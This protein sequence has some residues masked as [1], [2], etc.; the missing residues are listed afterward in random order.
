MVLVVKN[1]PANAG[2]V[3]DA[4]SIPGLGR[5]P[6]RGNGKS[7]QYPCLENTMERGAWQATMHREA[8]SWTR[9]E[10]TQ[11]VVYRVLPS[12]TIYHQIKSVLV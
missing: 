7:L 10:V 2:N 3:R 1:L 4:G 8:K 12:P 9:L 11:H 5:F 6:G